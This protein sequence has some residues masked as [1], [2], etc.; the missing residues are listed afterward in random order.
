[1]SSTRSPYPSDVSDEEWA[2]VV[3]YLTLLPEDV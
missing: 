1:M 2:F 3:P